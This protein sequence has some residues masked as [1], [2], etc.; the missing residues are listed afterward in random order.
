MR[1]FYSM[2]LRSKVVA[3]TYVLFVVSWNRRALRRVLYSLQ[4]PYYTIFRLK[5]IPYYDHYL[6]KF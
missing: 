1:T 3:L 5:D 6:I 2:G 4:P